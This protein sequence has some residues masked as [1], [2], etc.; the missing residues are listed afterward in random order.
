[1]CYSFSRDLEQPTVCLATVL[2]IFASLGKLQR[3]RN[4][5]YNNLP[6]S[7]STRHIFLATHATNLLQPWTGI[8]ALTVSG[9]SKN[10]QQVDT[11][12]LLEKCSWQ[13]MFFFMA[14]LHLALT[15]ATTSMQKVAVASPSLLTCSCWFWGQRSWLSSCRCPP[16]RGCHFPPHRKGLP[17]PLQMLHTTLPP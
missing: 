11:K 5:L 4:R 13:N 8:T 10:L 2:Q 15:H 7:L 14:K 3:C 9:Y 16:T 17:Q 6:V 1:M 12:L